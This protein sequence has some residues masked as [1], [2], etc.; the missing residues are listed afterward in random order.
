M[1]QEI[2]VRVNYFVAKS[3]RNR[4][5]SAIYHCARWRGGK[6]C[7][8]TDVASNRVKQG[9]P[10]LGVRGGRQPRIPSRRFAGSHKLRKDLDVAVGVFAAIDTGISCAGLVVRSII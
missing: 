9:S 6:G 7:D 8:V 2:A 1:Q 3:C 4:K 5:R 10:S